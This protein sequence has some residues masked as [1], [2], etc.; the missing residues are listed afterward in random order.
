VLNGTRLL[1]KAFVAIW[2]HEM[3]FLNCHET[4]NP[5]VSGNH[6]ASVRHFGGLKMKF[7]KGHENLGCRKHGSGEQ[8]FVI[9]AA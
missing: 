6:K 5:L 3:G 2:G 9:L 4:L 8:L 1:V 7:F